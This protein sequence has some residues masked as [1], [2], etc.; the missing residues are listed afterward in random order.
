M[1][2]LFENWP[3]QSSCD[4]FK[5]NGLFANKEKMTNLTKLL[6]FRN[7]EGLWKTI[8]TSFLGILKIPMTNFE[9]LY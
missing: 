2:L 7:F 3:K 1:F 5:Y 4:D 6:N 9:I 8:T